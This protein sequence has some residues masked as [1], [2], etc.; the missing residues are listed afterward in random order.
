MCSWPT[1]E[2]GDSIVNEAMFSMSAL[3]IEREASGWVGKR[4]GTGMCLFQVVCCWMQS[5]DGT[6]G[7]SL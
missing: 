3:T 2:L 1:K 6:R 4:V 7:S 5:N